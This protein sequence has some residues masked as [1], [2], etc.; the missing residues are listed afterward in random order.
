MKKKLDLPRWKAPI[1]RHNKQRL[2][3]NEGTIPDEVFY[4]FVSRISSADVSSYPEYE[5]LLLRLSKYCSKS[6]GEILITNGADQAIDI[7]ISEFLKGKKVLLPSPVFSYY[8]HQ[9]KVM[10]IEY[11]TLKY[12]ILPNSFDF[13]TQSVLD[14]IDNY[15]ALVIC[16]PNNPLGSELDSETI[17]LLVMECERKNKMIV[18]DQCYLEYS[19]NRHRIEASDFVLV[20]RTFSKYFGM[21]GA[22]LGYITSSEGNIGRMLAVRGPWDVNYFAASLGE[23]CLGSLERFQAKLD[24]LLSRKKDLELFFEEVGVSTYKTSTNFNLV[25][26]DDS[27]FVTR[28]LS[29]SGV[30]ISDLTSYPDD[31]GMLSGLLRIGIPEE[32]DM[33]KFKNIFEIS[34]AL[35]RKEK[36]QPA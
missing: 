27:E 36:C 29:E 5:P 21:S 18:I 12:D 15:D 13:P 32:S 6:V 8:Q 35:S 28:N 33:G 31:F 3:L 20:I 25:R 19:K 9:M 22:R 26:V 14:N 10:G 17:E 16:D 7:V 11:K 24:S 30:L 34:L 23:S 1:N 2:D 4:E